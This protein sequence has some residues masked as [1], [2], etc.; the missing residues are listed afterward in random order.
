M[1]CSFRNCRFREK[2]SKAAQAHIEGILYHF[3]EETEVFILMLKTK[4]FVKNNH[5]I[6]RKYFTEIVTTFYNRGYII[7]MCSTC[8]LVEALSTTSFI[9]H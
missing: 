3:D 4:L 2:L 1:K 8:V 9:F 6:S 5:H 7:K